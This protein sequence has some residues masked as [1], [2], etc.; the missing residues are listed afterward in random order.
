MINALCCVYCALWSY[1]W[2]T[3]LLACY[4]L[5]PGGGSQINSLKF[6]KRSIAWV[7]LVFLSNL[8]PPTPDL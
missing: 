3:L 2:I 8:N 4:L 6:L 5:A 1:L 7:H